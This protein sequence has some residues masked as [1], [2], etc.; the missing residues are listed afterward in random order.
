MEIA[1]HIKAEMEVD[2]DPKLFPAQT[3]AEMVV[4]SRKRSL[5]EDDDL[6]VQMKKM[7]E[8]SRIVSGIHEIYGSLYDEIG[9][10]RVL[11]TCPV[12]ASVMKDMVMARLA[13]PCSKRSSAEL[14]ERDFG[15]TIPLEKIYRMMD[16][17]TPGRM[18]RL[19]DYCWDHSRSLLTEEIKVMFY[20]CTTLYFESFT[21]DELRS[22]GYSKDHKFNQGQ[23]LL[24]LMVTKEGLPAGYEVFPGNMYEGDTFK[25]AIYK[26]RMRYGVKRAIVV[27]DSALLSKNN[28]ELLAR[29]QFEFI[30]GARLKSLSVKWQDRILDNTDYQQKKQGDEVVGL[31]SYSYTKDRRLIVSHSAKRAEKDR[32]DRER[33]IERLRQKL[34]ESKKPQSLISNYGYK[35]FLKVEGDVQVGVNEK[36]MEHEALW[37]GLHGVF[38]NIKED[39]MNAEEV[40]SQYHGLWQVE[41]SFRITKHD[42]RVR[43]VFHW[44]AKRIRA[45]IALCF[46]AFSLIRFLQYRIT[47][48]T[49]ERFSAEKI[50]EELFRIQESILRYKIDYSRYVVPSKPS[51]DALKIYKAMNMERHVVPFKLN[52]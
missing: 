25:Q 48:K 44:S 15:I 10:S 19:Q 22:F 24:A 23:V 2:S 27:A 18:N 7:R 34:A 6:P 45:H 28:I 13:R 5:E 37:D 30:L 39:D 20:D 47:Q 29:E 3:L 31:V 49:G 17:L 50:R 26:I 41:E 32:M 36:K 16:T 1:E 40:L 52:E 51:E 14:L 21:E 33:S 38:T 4:T 11:R 12:S 42:L 46:V 43:P 9:F 35:K 8:E